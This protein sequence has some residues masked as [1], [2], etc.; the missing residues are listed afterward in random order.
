MNEAILMSDTPDLAEVSGIG[1]HEIPARR[2][3]LF[4]RA[5]LRL[6]WLGRGIA[7]A[8]DWLFGVAALVIGL[9]L[10]SAVPIVQFLS[11]GYLLE[12]GGRVAASGQLRAGLVG[13]RK[14]SRVGSMVIGARLFLLPLE[15]ISSLANSAQVI[16]PGGPSARG[17]KTLLVVATVLVVI[18]ILAA[19]AR[20]GRIRHFLLPFGNPSWI[21]RRV[22]KGGAYASMRDAVWEFA[23]SLHLPYYFRLGFLGFLG[24]MVWLALPVTL[25]AAGRRNP[26]LGI[27]GALLLGLVAMPL[28][29]LQAKFAVENRFR[30]MFALKAVRQR[31]RNA[32]WAFAF[33]LFVALAASVPLYLLKIEMIPRETVWLPSLVFLIFMY[34]AR[35]LTGWA[36]GRSVRRETPRHWFFRWTGRL[37][38]LPVTAAYVLIVFLSQ[39]TAWRGIWSLYEQQAFLLPVPFLGM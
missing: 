26:L 12:A 1:R 23:A 5:I 20:G 39:F 30:S 3:G 28:P 31:F 16:D 27:L 33:S 35:I 21:I 17:W 4:S 13:V 2:P 22:K 15:L 8:S 6:R 29:Y 18:H 9:A 10:L 38:M 25:I 11:F 19:C 34:P 32:P 14:A 7:S 24:T 37:G 36:Y